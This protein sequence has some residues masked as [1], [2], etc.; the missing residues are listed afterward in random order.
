LGPVLQQRAADGFTRECHGDLHLRNLA[1]LQEKIVAFDCI[2][3]D[4]GL[5]W[6]D[7]IDD[8]AFLVMDLET[9]ERL[10]LSSVLLDA[11]LQS[12][13]DYA[14]LGLLRFYCMYRAL[15]RAKVAAIQ[16]SNEADKS[17]GSQAISRRLA[18][19]SGLVAR[20]KPGL[21]LLHG[22]PASGKSSI[23][24]ALVEALPGIRIS[25]DVERKRLAG[26]E[27]D[28]SS[29]S[30]IGQGIYSA[31]NNEATYNRLRLAAGSVLHAGRN[32]IVDA[33]FLTQADRSRFYALAAEHGLTTH[34]THC[35]APVDELERRIEKRRQRAADSEADKAVLA[36]AIKRQQPVKPGE[37]GVLV[38]VDTC[39]EVDV[40]TLVSSLLRSAE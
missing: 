29:D 1:L 27:R 31:E 36:H 4:A 37:A 8:L 15:V 17:V 24:V 9:N 11:Y 23:A 19:A 18:Y 26:L 35:V 22:L 12:T 32:A 33:T 21:F 13:G 14:G 39:G 6:I 7:V 34:V 2:E 5:R 16:R 30:S 40:K 25:S 10:E 3:F 20:R 38:D 28:A